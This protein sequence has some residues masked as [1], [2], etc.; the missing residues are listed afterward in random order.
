MSLSE[1]CPNYEQILLNIYED[2]EFEP[3]YHLTH[4]CTEY[5]FS[6]ILLPKGISESLMY[7]LNEEHGFKLLTR[8][9]PTSR[10]DQ[11]PSLVRLLLHFLFG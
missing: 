2:L 11:P 6:I 3:I 1:L 9:R 7:E 5:Q 10:V 4:R 8:Q